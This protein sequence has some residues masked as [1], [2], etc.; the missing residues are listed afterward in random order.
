MGVMLSDLSR[1][2]T[3]PLRLD[4]G[5]PR[6]LW[7]DDW[8]L[9]HLRGFEHWGNRQPQRQRGNNFRRH[10]I[11]RS[12]TTDWGATEEDDHRR[13]L[14]SKLTRAERDDHRNHPREQDRRPNQY[15]RI[16]VDQ[17]EADE[18]GPAKRVG[19]DPLVNLQRYVRKAR[20]DLHGFGWAPPP[21]KG[22][23]ST[24]DR[25]IQGEEDET[26]RR[27][28]EAFEI[29]QGTRRGREHRLR[30]NLVKRAHTAQ[31]NSAVKACKSGVSTLTYNCL[32]D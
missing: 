26:K 7:P 15:D 29:L 17:Y 13:R 23:R 32:A 19:I 25:A 6:V 10:H 27:R 5:S 11:W 22:I 18:H 9:P 3:D 1:A 2:V 8:R 12:G 31:W 28:D 21:R 4:W 20:V 16:G 14:E 24:W 30:L